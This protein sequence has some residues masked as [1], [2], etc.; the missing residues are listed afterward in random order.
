MG[1]LERE[2]GF[3]VQTCDR[4]ILANIVAAALCEDIRSS[5]DKEEHVGCAGEFV[6]VGDMRR[7]ADG[8]GEGEFEELDGE[9]VLDQE[10]NIR[11]FIRD[12]GRRPE[13]MA[14]PWS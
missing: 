10:K 12:T 8:V 7:Q 11:R 1:R 13:K 14:I 6:N 3:L 9:L 2:V 4:A 5:L